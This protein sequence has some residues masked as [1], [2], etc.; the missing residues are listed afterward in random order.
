MFDKDDEVSDCEL[1]PSDDGSNGDNTKKIGDLENNSEVR[2]IHVP[3]APRKQKFVNIEEI[4]A[5][6][7]FDSLPPE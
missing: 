6:D 4:K 1:M 2:E 3:E 5:L 7:N